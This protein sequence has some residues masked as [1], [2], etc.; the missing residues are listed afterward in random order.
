MYNPEKLEEYAQ[1]IYSRYEYFNNYTLGTIRRRIK[2]TGALSA[3]DRQALKNIADISGDMGAITKKLAEITR[4]NI[5]DIERIY[6]EVI[7]D[8]VNTY[9]PL[10]DFKGMRFVPFGENE[11]A[12]QLV[13]SWA[14]ETA[15]EMINLSRT[16]A[17]CFDRVDALGNVVGS[18]PLAGAFQEVIDEAVA[19]VSAGTVNFNTAMAKTV[20][21]LGGSGVKVSYG[22]G[23]NRSL[24]AVIRQN[25]LYGAKRSAQSY[26]EHIGKALGCDGFEVDA[27]PGCRPSHEF[28]QGKMYSYSGRKIVGGTVYEDGAEALE[29]LED[30]NCLHFK[31][32][33]ILGVSQPSYSAEELERIHKESTELIEYNGREKTLYEWKRTQRAFERSVR[34]E[35]QKADMLDAAG[36]KRR[37]QECRQR[38]DAYRRTYD[39]MCSKVKGLEPHPERMGV[40]KGVDFSGKSGIIK[41]I[42]KKSINYKRF[43]INNQ[44]DYD[45]WA[46]AYY[47]QN[48]PKLTSH[49]YS[50]LKEYTDG[51][52]TAINAATRFEVGSEPYNKVCKQYGVHN[53]DKYKK[54][55]DD[56]SKAVKKFELDDDIICHR[57][58]PNVDYI[59]GTTSS[60]NDLAKAAGAE[61]TDKGFTSTCLFEHLTEKFGGK[62]PIHLE[63]R[64][65]RKT[66]GAYIND[67]SE[68]KNLEWEYLLDRGTRFKVLEGGER[69]TIENKWIVAERAWKDVEKT[70]KYMI[71][72]VLK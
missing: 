71:L 67:F 38:A 60:V 61:Y 20:E 11:Y 29:R 54:L 2:A 43:D 58:V 52:Y 69:K 13:G 64:I 28:M 8:G 47:S 32:D 22:N 26:D 53:L 46:N 39:D 41:E 17:L 50:V 4:L 7:T 66:P 65:P 12:R 19:A 37:A 23:V 63:I 16:K 15:G 5:S 49:D 35:R 21:R 44:K 45:G 1:V 3:A 56:I 18:T 55:S 31:T 33:V 42:E 68:K 59:T 48:K 9:K 24:S 34:G 6:E 25:I 72:E 62:T 51:S 57:Y 10:Y 27:H 70:E 14:K 40:Y 36:M 30:Y